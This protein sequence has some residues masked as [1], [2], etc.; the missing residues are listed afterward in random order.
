M[1]VSIHSSMWR[2]LGTK[3]CCSATWCNSGTSHQSPNWFLVAVNTAAIF[4]IAPHG[5]AMKQ[6]IPILWKVSEFLKR[7]EEDL[8]PEAVGI[9]LKDHKNPGGGGKG[10][11]GPNGRGQKVVETQCGKENPPRTWWEGKAWRTKWGRKRN[12]D[13]SDRGGLGGPGQVETS[14][15]PLN[16]THLIGR[17]GDESH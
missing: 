11:Q 8:G 15:A 12:T 13:I 6:P 14:C 2:K 9:R 16:N 7:C 3:L 4:R 5:H 10:L 17:A 1:K